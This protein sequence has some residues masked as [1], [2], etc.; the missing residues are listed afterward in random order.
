[1]AILSGVIAF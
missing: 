1:M